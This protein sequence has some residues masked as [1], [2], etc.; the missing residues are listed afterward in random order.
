[1]DDLQFLGLSRNFKATR[2]RLT[3]LPKLIDDLM[4]DELSLRR[5]AHLNSKND[6][7]A[8]IERIKKEREK[9]QTEM[10]ERKAFLPILRKQ[11][12]DAS[13]ELWNIKTKN[14]ANK[15]DDLKD[16]IK[17]TK[18]RL[19]ET[20][21]DIIEF[22]INLWGSEQMATKLMEYISFRIEESQKY[23]DELSKISME[24]QLSEILDQHKKDQDTLCR[25]L[26]VSSVDNSIIS[27][28]IISESSYKEKMFGW[29]DSLTGAREPKNHTI[30]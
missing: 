3:Q 11:L 28:E 22:A 26:Q 9:L 25:L 21:S 5:D 27:S 10:I 24:K 2:E 15:I 7:K 4:A 19:E 20:V 14:E 13:R 23:E 16:K 29:I 8:E 6:L 17:T 1:M 12:V 18:I 30:R